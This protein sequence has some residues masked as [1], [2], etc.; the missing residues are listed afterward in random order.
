MPIG[1]HVIFYDKVN[2]GYNEPDYSKVIKVL[3]QDNFDDRGPQSQ[4]GD[5]SV[6]QE[7]DDFSYQSHSF[8]LCKNNENDNNLHGPEHCYCPGC[9]NCTKWPMSPG[10]NPVCNPDDYD[11]PEGWTDCV[12]SLPDVI[13]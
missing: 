10:C 8:C 11:T 4:P 2:Y 3:I 7:L 6:C 1:Y 12:C 5:F 13:D 9:E